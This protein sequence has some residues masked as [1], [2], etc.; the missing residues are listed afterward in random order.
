MVANA[1][2]LE[3]QWSSVTPSCEAV[4]YLINASN[5][6]H[7]PDVTNDTTAICTDFALDKYSQVCLLSVQTVVCDNI[8]GNESSSVEVN[9]RGTHIMSHLSCNTMI[10]VF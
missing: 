2:Q 7:C 3:F 9:L 10:N 6:G 8:F 1:H 4:H 5:C